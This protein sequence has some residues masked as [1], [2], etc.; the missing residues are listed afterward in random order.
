MVSNYMFNNHLGKACL[1]AVIIIGLAGC[2]GSSKSPTPAEPPPPAADAGIE[3]VRTAAMTAAMAAATAATAAEAAVNAQDDNQ[4]ADPGSYAVARNAAARARAAAGAAQA[5][6]DAAAAATTTV[7]AQAQLDIAEAKQAEAVAERANAVMYAGMVQTAQNAI[8]AENQRQ[9]DVAD[10]RMRAMGSYMDADAD[11]TKAEAQADAAE[12]TAAGTPGAMAARQAATAARTA[13]TAAKA[14]HDAITDGM[15][16]AEADAQATEAATQ[17]SNAN[18]SYMTAKAENDDIQTAAGISDEQNRQR[19]VAAATDAAGTAAMAARASATAAR[20]SATAARTAATAARN[21]YMKAMMARTDSENAQMKYMDADAAATAAENAAMAAETA[22]G[23]AETAHM[24]I[25][26]DGSVADAK[27]AQM[28]A[29]ARQ[30]D[31]AGSAGTASTQQMTAETAQGDAEMAAGTQVVGLLMMANAAHIAADDRED[32][33]ENVNTAVKAANDDATDPSHGGGTVTSVTWPYW[34]SLGS[35]TAIGGTGDNADTGPGEGRRA[36]T[37]TPAGGDA[38]SLRHAGP[39]ADGDAGTDDDLAANYEMGPGLGDFDEFYISG[40]DATTADDLNDFNTQRVILFTDLEQGS[41]GRAAQVVRYINAPVVQSRIASIGAATGQNYAATYDHDD[42][43]DTVAIDVT[44]NCGTNC[45]LST[46]DGEV[47]SISGYT[48]STADAGVTVAAVAPVEDD[49][50]LGF[51]VWL[52]ETVVADGTNTY[53]FGAFADGGAA[54][55]DSGEPTA[56]AAVT[57]D[58]TYTGKAAGVHS[59]ATAV[60]FFQADATLTAK[61]GNGTEIGTITGSIHNIV[62]GGDPVTGSIEL[63][64]NDPGAA[65]PTDNIVDGG[66]FTGRARMGNTGMQDSSGEAI[67]RYTGTWGGAFYNH[68]AA[69][70]TATV[71]PATRA[72]GSVAGTF[73]VGRADVAS[74]MDM[75]ETE[76][77]V[78]AFGAHCS[79]SNCNSQ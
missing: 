38:L 49:T 18:A 21:A 29:E 1:A 44:L 6:S 65:D 5:A 23:A 11:A 41:M 69:D 10:A 76:S 62:A 57:G 55:G 2:S 39:G 12:A 16:K 27:A 51:G 54:V 36:I 70:A 20:A 71:D 74:T 28:T 9:L 79:G 77:Y 73:G 19:D 13:A 53:A 24:G 60:D 17:A 66:T 34:A 40:L 35:D 52:V 63:V 72:P 3:D 59:T 47:V 42:N 68:M 8:D 56:V 33:V 46:V 45:S 26:A 31:A 15:S 25:D 14:A 30:T 61:F 32:H 43:E 50:W 37:V 4:A 78:G 64:V 75:D 7:A 67:Y 22:A 58:A 48:F